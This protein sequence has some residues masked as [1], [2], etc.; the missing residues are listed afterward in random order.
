MALVVPDLTTS[1]D[2]DD[3]LQ[4][5]IQI[6]KTRLN[7]SNRNLRA[8]HVRAFLEW[9]PDE[10]R[11]APLI[12]WDAIPSR[13]MAYLI[14]NLGRADDIGIAVTLG[15]GASSGAVGE[16]SLYVMSHSLASVL[17][18]IQDMGM[19]TSIKQT[20]NR[21]VWDA[22]VATYVK[23]ESR[24]SFAPG[25]A[26]WLIRYDSVTSVHL[27]TYLE[28]IRDIDPAQYNHLRKYALAPL[29]PR[30]LER[31]GLR[32]TLKEDAQRRRKE[33]ADVL[34][35]LHPFLVQLVQFRKQAMDRIIGAYREQC[36]RV[37]SGKASLPVSFD[38]ETTNP[39]ITRD[40]ATHAG[41]DITPVPVTLRCTLWSRRTWAEANLSRLGRGAREEW[42]YKMGTYAP[43]SNHYFLQCHNEPGEL[44]WFGDVIASDLLRFLYSPKS[45]K[46]HVERAMALGVPGGCS[47]GRS[48]LLGPPR[49]TSIWFRHNFTNGELV[50]EPESLWRGVLYASALATVALTSGAR[51]GEILQISDL[52]WDL[53]EVDELSDGKP[54]GRRIRVTLQ[55][56]LPKGFKTDSDRQPFLISPQA[57][58]LLLEI[59]RLLQAQHDRVPIVAPRHT[60]RAELEPEPYIFQ[61]DASD[62]GHMGGL[63]INDV[64]RL[65]RFIFLGLEVTT[66]GGEP[67]RIAT[68][69][70]RHVLAASARHQYK[71][72]PEAIRWLLH[73]RAVRTE[74]VGKH[75]IPE[76]TE[77]YT[78]S[79]ELQL[80]LLHEAQMEIANVPQ[81]FALQLPTQAELDTMDDDLREVFEN[82]GTIG[83][84]VLGFCKAGMCIRLNNR[85]QCVGCPF[86]V[87]DYRRMGNALRWRKIY[88][89]AAEMLEASGHMTDARQKRKEL[90]ML[91]G[92]INAMRLQIKAIKDGGNVPDFL[93]LPLPEDDEEAN[94]G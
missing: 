52:R 82:W 58:P 93:S 19:L 30:F 59:A 69:L 86:L 61:W 89:A 70:C 33:S 8:E 9:L 43:E 55:H 92:H 39:T 53:S 7:F 65:L 17:G 81:P 48:G 27:P 45:S 85:A 28:T 49:S 71:V 36:R 20:A 54:T 84:T 10:L 5:E 31:N 62:D 40:V 57:V 88:L 73:H 23:D 38:I 25:G 41:I 18:R 94:L 22:F 44:L 56:L 90:E 35:P 15:I 42:T 78:E 13:V 68:H 67:I 64:G 83:P 11:Q 80:A 77:Y 50:F 91:D 12:D 3:E 87:V 72:P 29:P 74:M 47:T 79:R 76:A 1:S 34:V 51:V 21:A 37:E 63:T 60:H 66:R 46:T 75:A 14:R 24:A 26:T 4:E 6:G 2:D 32:A 16:S